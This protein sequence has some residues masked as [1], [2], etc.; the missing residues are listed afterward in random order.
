MENNQKEILLNTEYSIIVN[1][2]GK[3]INKV[4][5]GIATNI[6][7]G[8]PGR[9]K[10]TVDFSIEENQ[11][12]LS[13]KKEIPFNTSLYGDNKLIFENNQKFPH[14]EFSFPFQFN[15]VD[16]NFYQKGSLKTVKITMI[17][18]GIEVFSND[19]LNE[20]LST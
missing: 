2:N 9:T 17:V 8:L 7:K 4:L 14:G 10:I 1:E 6:T 15:G 3:K 19:I 11:H 16:C 13:Y 18:G 12:T 5:K 20:D